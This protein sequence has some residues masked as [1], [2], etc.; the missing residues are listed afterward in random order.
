[1]HSCIAPTDPIRP[2]PLP[3]VLLEGELLNQ[4]F[5]KPSLL[6]SPG[7]RKWT[8]SLP[9][10]KLKHFIIFHFPFKTPH[11]FSKLSITIISPKLLKNCKYPLTTN[12]RIKI[13]LIIFLIRQK[14]SYKFQ[15]MKK[16]NFI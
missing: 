5:L 11:I 15:K 16:Y 2:Q 13:I 7:I 3:F 9:Y 12:K 1:L 8:A 4:R 10:G 6:T 14:Y